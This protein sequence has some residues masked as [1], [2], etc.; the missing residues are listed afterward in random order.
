MTV[1]AT[2]FAFCFGMR[3]GMLLLS[4]FNLFSAVFSMVAGSLTDTSRPGSGRADAEEAGGELVVALLLLNSFLGYAAVRTNSKCC[5]LA[6]VVS[7]GGLLFL[8][9]AAF[10]KGRP[11]SCSSAEVIDSTPLGASTP[12]TAPRPRQLPPTPTP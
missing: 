6:L 11:A 3:E 2:S 12:S 9:C 1:F 8:L 7:F 10:E 4:G 5:A